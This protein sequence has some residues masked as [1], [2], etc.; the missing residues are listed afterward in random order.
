MLFAKLWG[1]TGYS[2][3]ASYVRDSVWFVLFVFGFVGC[4]F[5]VLSEDFFTFVSQIK[6]REFCL[7]IS[8]RG[9]TQHDMLLAVR[10]CCLNKQIQLQSQF[11]HADRW[12][13]W[14][15]RFVWAEWRLIFLWLTRLFKLIFTWFFSCY[16]SSDMPKQQA[17]DD[18]CIDEGES[19]KRMVGQC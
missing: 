17:F 16:W 11:S 7:K 5:I 19:I 4:F 14:Y 9:S 13:F 1:F 6:K 2:T 12:E 18:N 3:G 10:L 8:T 15:N